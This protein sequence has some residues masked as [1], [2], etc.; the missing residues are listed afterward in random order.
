MGSFRPTRSSGVSAP[1]GLCC[2]CTWSARRTL[3]RKE[4]HWGI[5]VR[6]DL[7]PVGSVGREAA[8]APSGSVAAPSSVRARQAALVT[9]S[10]SPGQAGGRALSTPQVPKGRSELVLCAG[11]GRQVSAVPAQWSRG[12]KN[13]LNVHT[14]SPTLLQ[15]PRRCPSEAAPLSSAGRTSFLPRVRHIWKLPQAAVFQ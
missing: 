1:C 3:R 15:T 11:S 4:M 8:G 9:S 10:A 7:P 12:F 6:T 13:R 14:A 5:R 2:V